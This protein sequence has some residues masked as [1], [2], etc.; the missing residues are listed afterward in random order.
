MYDAVAAAADEL[1]KNGKLRKQA[2]L[3]ITDGED[4][5]SRLNLN[6]TVRRV[7]NLGGPV[8]YSIGLL[9]DASSQESE[10]TRTA[11]ETLSRETGGVAYFPRSLQEVDGIA[12][13]LASDIRDQYTVAY[14]ASKSASLG[15]YRVVQVQA[16]A[17]N[18]TR[19]NVRTRRGY[20]ANPA[21]QTQPGQEAKQ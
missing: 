4:N 19:L 13:E 11:L 15:G 10:R 16:Q 18:H 20:Y 14:H 1:A 3:I 12:A 17:S 6:E 9:F 8:V 2:I 5:A 7:Q 21:H